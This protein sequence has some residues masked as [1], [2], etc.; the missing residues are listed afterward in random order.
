[1]NG[2]TSR[3]ILVCVVIFLSVVGSAISESAG[4]TFDQ[5]IARRDKLNSRQVAV[6]GFFDAERLIL[7]GAAGS[8]RDPVAID[9]SAKQARDFKRNG[10]LHS[11]YVRIVGTFQY[12]G[13]PKVL[14][15][16]GNDPGRSVPMSLPTGF[17]G[18][19]SQQITNIAE[20]VSVSKRK[21]N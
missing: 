4:I 11:G 13:A 21:S 1:M 5:L 6:T 17:R 3:F 16:P 12:V 15:P 7:V 10:L 18:V 8:L 9:L 2:K 19:Y 20:F 14:G